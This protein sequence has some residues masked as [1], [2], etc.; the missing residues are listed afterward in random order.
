MRGDELCKQSGQR[1]SATVLPALPALLPLP[2]QVLRGRLCPY[3]ASF[4]LPGAEG[5]LSCP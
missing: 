1:K 5:T 3:T 4:G 2:L